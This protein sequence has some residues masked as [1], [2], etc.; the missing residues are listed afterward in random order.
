MNVVCFLAEPL[1]LKD[2]CRR[3]IRK[4]VGRSHLHLINQLTLPTSLRNYLVYH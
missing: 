1:Q 4:R 3:L 2:S